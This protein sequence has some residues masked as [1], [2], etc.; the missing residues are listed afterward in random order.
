MH[1]IFRKIK[2]YIKRV[3]MP[4]GEMAL[5]GFRMLF[6]TFWLK[7]FSLK[8]MIKKNIVCFFP[9]FYF[10]GISVLQILLKTSTTIDNIYTEKVTIFK[11]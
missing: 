10:Y 2:T 8:M 5:F 7:I 3:Q 1:G 11:K 6:S 9:S 4:N